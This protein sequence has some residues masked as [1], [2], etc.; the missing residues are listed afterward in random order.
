[1][2]TNKHLLLFACLVFSSSTNE[3][4]K[5]HYKE[6]RFQVIELSPE[7][8]DF[9]SDRYQ[10]IDYKEF[11]EIQQNLAQKNQIVREI[12]LEKKFKH[13]ESAYCGDD[14]CETPMYELVNYGLGQDKIRKLPTALII[15]GVHGKETLGIQVLVRFIEMVQ[16]LYELKSDI[17]RLFNNIRLLIIPAINMNGFYNR[18]NFE[19][20]L[21]NNKIHEIDPAV[22]F[23][24]RPEAN[25]FSS[26]SSQFIYE[27]HQN[28][29]ITGSLMLTEGDF[30]V[31]FSE[32]SRL[33][34]VKNKSSDELIMKK[35]AKMVTEDMNAHVKTES[36]TFTLNTNKPLT[37]DKSN[38]GEGQTGRYIDW[39]HCA[40][41]YK[42]FIQADCFLPNNPFIKDYEEIGENTNRAIAIEI[43]LNKKLIPNIN[44]DLGNSTLFVN[45]LSVVAER[46]VIPAV[47]V[48]IKRFLEIL[49]PYPFLKSIRVYNF[50]EDEKKGTI[51]KD[52]M[53]F[54][55]YFF[56]TFSVD[57]VSYNSENKTGET[58]LATYT[59]LNTTQYE[60]I[61]IAVELRDSNRYV[62]GKQNDVHFRM[63]YFGEID[64][65]ISKHG[66]VYTHFLKA[67]TDNTYYPNVKSNRL[68]MTSFNNYTIEKFRMG[69][70][71]EGMIFQQ[72]VNVSEFYYETEWVIGFGTYYPIYLSY[73]YSTME[74]W[75]SVYDGKS[76][77][78]RQKTVYQDFLYNVGILNKLNDAEY[79][80]EFRDL[81]SNVKSVNKD[82]VLE[83]YNSYK[84]FICLNIFTDKLKENYETLTEQLKTTLKQ[85]KDIRLANRIDDEDEHKKVM[86]K[87]PKPEVPSEHIEEELNRIQCNQFY[88]LSQKQRK[89]RSIFFQMKLNKKY[90]MVPSMFFSLLGRMVRLNLW[91]KDSGKL[92]DDGKSNYSAK[93]ILGK[94]LISDD[95][96][97]GFHSDVEPIRYANPGRFN[98]YSVSTFFKLNN[99]ELACSSL[100]PFQKV[101]SQIMENTISE[102]FKKKEHN[103]YF[104]SLNIKVL[105]EE[106]GTGIITL[107]TNEPNPSEKYILY[108][109]KKEF[110]LVYNFNKNVSIT[111][112][113]AKN[114]LRLYE[115]VFPVTDLGL[116]GLLVMVYPS[117]SNFTSFECFLNLKDPQLNVR[118]EFIIHKELIDELKD[119]TLQSFGMRLLS[120][121]DILVKYI[122]P[123]I[124]LIVFIIAPFVI[125]F[126]YYRNP[127][128]KV[129]NADQKEIKDIE[130][131]KSEEKANEKDE[132]K[133]VNKNEESDEEKKSEKKEDQDE[134]DKLSKENSDQLV[135]KLVVEQ[136]ED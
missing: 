33:F 105:D 117:D 31:N 119:M 50:K 2:I 8:T 109:K 49:T 127:Q 69:F 13:I 112:K 5:K 62:K 126:V 60:V 106:K 4:L 35:I 121:R 98:K 45:P 82:M 23:N 89:R 93:T 53:I 83:I 102:S 68:Q 71:E 123:M 58:N 92:L 12:I 42:E 37:N 72:A 133:I 85:E 135:D 48:G 11:K 125:W 120:N 28:Y 52:L 107:F 115:G 55:F 75:F 36:P 110:E 6:E 97:T 77:N 3:S 103:H 64:K 44:E 51:N 26:S 91:S 46:G 114:N 66:D 9:K 1:M 94:I 84:Y 81:I 47:M 78:E 21:M 99:K 118:T 34:G 10:D 7:M 108:N 136:N 73:D 24:L 56:G 14:L 132:D 128:D 88:G 104:F 38:M 100:S 18:E 54:T 30:Q 122:I 15:G 39:A 65:V 113:Y 101:D 63:D 129:E 79:N 19:S 29:L 16:V 116:I 90:K 59:E 76:P 22:D 43:S 111:G 86:A 124:F 96:I 32:V 95:V 80:Q 87:L 130:G 131:E 70:L 27:I 25:C 67:L 40:S 57:S 17:F 74:T 61:R 20:F 134:E 41:V